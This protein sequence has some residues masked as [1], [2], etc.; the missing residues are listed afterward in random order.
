MDLKIVNQDISEARLFRTTGNFSR[1]TGQEVAK[2]LYIS[3]LSTYMMLKDEEQSNY[4]EQY[5]K[6]TVQY[7]P[8]TLFRSHATDLYLLAYHVRNP[9]NRSIKLKNNIVSKVYLERLNFDERKHHMFFKK[10]S[11][12]SVSKSEANTY[13]MRLE[14][15]LKITDSKYKSYRR[16]ISDWEKLKYTSRQYVVTKLLQEYRQLGR[17]SELVDPLTTMA[18]YKSYRISDQYKDRKPRTSLA[19]RAVGTAAGAVAGRYAGKKIAQKL[20]KNVDKYKK[21][22][23]GIGAIAGYW[24]SGRLKK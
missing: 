8:Y 2:L 19:T 9:D 1:L 21:A 10:V 6:Q 14:S 18:K 7:G 11:N 16:L 22:G 13:F 23:T 15:Q 5:I 4:A 24:A 20:G 3:S 17:G 12:R